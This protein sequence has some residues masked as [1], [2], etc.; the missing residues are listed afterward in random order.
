MS[1][2]LRSDTGTY[3]V[4]FTYQD[5]VTG[6]ERRFRRMTGSKL[7][8]EAEEL[9]RRWRQEAETPPQPAEAK[10]NR[11]AFSGFAKYWLDTYAS[12]NCKPSY[13]RSSEQIIR[14]HLVPYFG[15]R[16]LRDIGM[17]LV[18]AY[19]AQKVKAKLAPKTVNNHLGVL[20]IIFKKA[21][22]WRYAEVNPVTGAGLLAV[23]DE[24]MAF[25]VEEQSDAFL[26]EVQ[27]HRP[28]WHAFFLCALRTGMRLGELLALTWGDVDFKV[29]EITVRRSWSHGKLTTPKN[30]KT[31]TLPMTPE[32]ALA[33]KGHRHLKGD[34]VFADADG[35]YLD[36][37][38]VKSRFWMGIRAAGVKE[39]RLH[40]LRHTF[41]SQ[42]VM[43]G[44]PL[45]AV[46]EYLGHATLEMTMRYAHLAPKEKEAWIARLDRTGRPAGREA[47]R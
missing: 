25:W 7:K 46:Q 35:H 21:V 14:V 32:L 1:V 19:K 20:S 2:Y 39:I 43:A 36:R 18:E 33:L 40:D 12:V 10:K 8:R 17:E 26:T 31:R 16:D 24:P 41:A 5:P 4:D 11:A 45:K 38:R 47:R 6:Q 28:E 3:R 30:G 37:N 13:C 42:L 29:N 15:D 27:R 22:Q 23:P 9:E 44:V 34:L